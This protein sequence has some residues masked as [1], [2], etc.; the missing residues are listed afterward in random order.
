MIDKTMIGLSF[1]SNMK[2]EIPIA[3]VLFS[4]VVLL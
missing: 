3:S 4:L 1:I 2:Y